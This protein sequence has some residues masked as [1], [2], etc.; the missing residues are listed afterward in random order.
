[1]VNILAIA[2]DGNRR[3]VN[4]V[5]RAHTL[6][7]RIGGLFAQII[8]F[9]G[10]S[11]S[12][13][14]RLGTLR[15]EELR[16]GIN[17]CCILRLII[18]NKLRQRGFGQNDELRIGG[19]LLN[20]IDDV[21]QLFICRIIKLLG[22]A[23]DIGLHDRNLHSLVLGLI[24]PENCKRRHNGQ[25]SH[26]ASTHRR[27]FCSMLQSLEDSYVGKQY[28]QRAAQHARIFIPLHSPRR[29]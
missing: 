23:I 28:P 4:I 18:I 7:S 6:T 26:H 17:A 15:S 8:I 14:H 29:A 1:M 11:T 3:V 20:Q 27:G 24:A 19:C 21:T 5:E 12:R 10:R 16:Q 2:T 13:N 25:Q 9:Y 22:I